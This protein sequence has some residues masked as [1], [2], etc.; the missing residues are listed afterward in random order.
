MVPIIQVARI[1][2]ASDLNG[3]PIHPLAVTG[4]RGLMPQIP[5]SRARNASGALNHHRHHQRQHRLK[6]KQE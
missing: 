5:Q 1:D 4:A 2:L 6:L 3:G